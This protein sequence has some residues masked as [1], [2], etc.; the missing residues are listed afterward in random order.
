[1]QPN[2]TTKTK[3]QKADTVKSMQTDDFEMILSWPQIVYDSRAAFPVSCDLLNN[4][5]CSVCDAPRHPDDKSS[6]SWRA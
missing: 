3:R 5:L 6:M 2:G 1:M 4:L